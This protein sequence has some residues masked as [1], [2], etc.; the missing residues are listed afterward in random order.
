MLVFRKLKARVWRKNWENKECSLVAMH[1]V[2][3]Q[4]QKNIN[5]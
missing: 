2:M 4:E 1:G 3:T 5:S